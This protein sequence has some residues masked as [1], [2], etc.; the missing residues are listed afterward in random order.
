MC[1]PISSAVD[2]PLVYYYLLLKN[3]TLLTCI[4][5]SPL[6]QAAEV[7]FPGHP[8]AHRNPT[9]LVVV[10]VGG[11]SSGGRRHIHV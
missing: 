1:E 8:E 10:V 5:H 7:V 6:S 11:V 4:P 3:K 2:G 9:P